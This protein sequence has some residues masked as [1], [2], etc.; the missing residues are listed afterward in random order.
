MRLFSKS[1]AVEGWM[2]VGFH[3]DGISAAHLKHS[4][5][6]PLVE[7]VAFYPFSGAAP[8]LALEKLEKEMDAG[9]FRCTSLLASGEYQMLSVDAPNVPSNE[10]KT[11]MRWRLKDMLDFHVDD[12]TFDVLAVPADKETASRPQ[13]M[14][15]VAARNQLIE[16]RQAAFEKSGLHL[17]VIDI[18]EMAQRNV[19]SLL[20]QEGRGLA[21]LSFDSTGGLLTITYAGE[22]YLARRIDVTLE[23]VMQADDVEGGALHDR[24][25]L[26]LQRSLDHFDRHYR[27]IAL[28]RL[29]LAPLGDAGQALQRYLSE[30]LYV[31]IE[32]IEL[33]DLF[34]ISRVPQLSQLH[35]Q[36]RQLLTLGAALRREEV[37]L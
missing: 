19:A 24:I 36:Q 16:Q 33:G 37:A 10:L 31:P 2:A 4:A 7:W 5:G 25:T 15:V 11:A 3:S 26:E 20:E 6:K 27:H 12:A 23:Q 22:L 8:E 28:S 34:D 1:K 9:G 35:T 29:V 17:N 21:L 14:Y 13:S 30:N 18:P 32:T